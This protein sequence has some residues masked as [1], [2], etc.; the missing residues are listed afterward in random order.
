[1]LVRLEESGLKLKWSKCLLMAPCDLPGILPL[2]EKVRAVQKAPEPKSVTNLKHISGL[3]S[4][5]GKLMPNLAHMI[6]PLYRLLGASTPWQWTSQ[7]KN[8]FEASKELLAAPRVLVHYDPQL[9]LVLACD[10]SP[11]GLGAV[12]AHCYPDG[13]EKPVAYPLFLLIQRQKRTTL[14]LRRRDWLVCSG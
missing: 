1:M 6:A 3:L 7:E 13:S 8:V 14:K 4:Y 9:P 10:A 5:Y 2:T 11:Y 12:L